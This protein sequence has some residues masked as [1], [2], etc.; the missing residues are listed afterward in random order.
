M[1]HNDNSRDTHVER[2]SYHREASL[3]ANMADDCLSIRPLMAAVE[4]KERRQARQGRTLEDPSVLVQQ[5]QATLPSP[6][7][8]RDTH[9]GARTHV[10]VHAHTHT[11]VRKAHINTSISIRENSHMLTPV[12]RSGLALTSL[13]VLPETNVRSTEK[14]TEKNGWTKQFH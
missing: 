3:L 8:D 14:A 4:S 2:A 1:F 6:A 13:C 10:H 12:E 5:P 7:G 9:K 11:V